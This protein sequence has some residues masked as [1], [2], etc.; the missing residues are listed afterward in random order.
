[1]I[2][3]FSAQ[4]DSAKANNDRTLSLKVDTQELSSEDTS[5]IFEFFQKQV[6]LTISETSITR[7][8]LNI[9]EVVEDMEKKSPSQRL[10]DRMFVFWKDRKASDNFDSWYKAQLEKIGENYLSKVQ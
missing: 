2:I 6:W 7:E 9:P 10:R 4:I 8:Q 3:Q 1:M 5:K